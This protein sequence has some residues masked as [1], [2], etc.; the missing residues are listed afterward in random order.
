[1][2]DVSQAGLDLKEVLIRG[3]VEFVYGEEARRINCSIH[4]KYVT[5]EGLSYAKVAAYLPKRDDI[6]I[7]IHMDHLISWNLASFN[8]GKALSVSSAFHPLDE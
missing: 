8:A 3:R 6:T 2:I 7:K 5:S 4:L 1:M